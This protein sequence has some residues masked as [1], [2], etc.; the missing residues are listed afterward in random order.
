M[1]TI[2]HSK[3]SCGR[4][5]VLDCQR[6]Q[7]YLIEMTTECKAPLTHAFHLI[8]MMVIFYGI[9][10]LSNRHNHNSNNAWTKHFHHC[11][12]LD[13][14]KIRAPQGYMCTE[15]ATA[16]P[17]RSVKTRFNR[18]AVMYSSGS[19]EETTII[20][21]DFLVML[22]WADRKRGVWWRQVLKWDNSP[23]CF[24]GYHSTSENKHDPGGRWLNR[25]IQK[26]TSCVS[27]E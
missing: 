2:N 26:R 17:K 23:H 1:W 10:D 25:E 13:W 7:L 3:D 22:T 16:K 8:N 24:Q 12:C 18:R 20:T 15:K 4:A 14:P 9:S 21:G 5:A 6:L 27:P 19:R 11:A